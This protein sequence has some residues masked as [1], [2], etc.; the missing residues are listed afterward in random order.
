[1]P[2]KSVFTR[3]AATAA[4]LI[5]LLS[6]FS[7]PVFAD[8]TVPG[9]IIVRVEPGTDVQKLAND[10]HTAI[11][12]HTSG[13]DL[14]R[15]RLPDGTTEDDFAAAVGKDHRVIYA[16]TDHY[17]LSPEVSGEPFHFAFDLSPKPAT[18]ANSAT[19]VQVGLGRINPN[20]RAKLPPPLATGAG[21]VVAVLDTG[22]T[23]GH[24]D[25]VGHYL[26]GFNA[27]APG[28]PPAEAAD[29]IVNYEVGHG[30]MVAG[31]IARL[32]PKAM[33]LPIRVL[34]GDGSGTMASLVAGVRYAVS[35][36][37]RVISMSFGSAVKSSALNDALDDA[38]HAGIV[39]VAAAG[40]DNGSDVIPPTVSRGTIAVAALEADNTKTAFSNYGSFVRVSAP[41]SNI[42]STFVDGGY[43]SWSGTSFA[44]P[45]VAAEAALILSVRPTFSAEDVKSTIRN[46]ARSVDDVNPAYRGQLGKGVIDID[47]AVRSVLR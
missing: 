1:V 34:N 15:F 45:F 25:L 12:D 21:I 47:A 42:R 18:Y 14:Y 22:A 3:L 44:A 26:P 17:V 27:I 28:T 20:G 7:R 2:L 10:Y 8:N 5:V 24:P 33:I 16:E 46:T 31:I 29:G 11:T 43:A 19:Y 35:H 30:T 41:G 37:A 9:Y 36:G 4:C 40:N 38:E 13:T 39:L 23:F 6:A 32:A